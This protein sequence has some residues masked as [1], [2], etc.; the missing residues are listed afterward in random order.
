M[1]DKKELYSGEWIKDQQVEEVTCYKCFTR[2][3][4][5]TAPQSVPQT[6]G[7]HIKEPHCP[8]CKCRL[9]WSSL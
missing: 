5:K 7:Y 3:N 1:R 8:N 2:Y 4:I 9:Y 6:G